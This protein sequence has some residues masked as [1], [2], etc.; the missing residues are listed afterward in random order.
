MYNNR[1]VRKIDSYGRLCIPKN[2]REVYDFKHGDRFEFFTENDLLCI[3][4]YDPT[5]PVVRKYPQGTSHCN[6]CLCSNCTGYACP[7]IIEFSRY[8]TDGLLPNRCEKCIRMN[9]KR[10]HDCDFYTCHKRVRFYA[11]RK[12]FF[13]ET[14]HDKVMRELAELKKILQERSNNDV[15]T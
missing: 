9:L 4:K 5:A 10:I 1:I 3:R 14:N 12:W 6:F 8:Q 15:R 7:W 11:K 13:K 2:I